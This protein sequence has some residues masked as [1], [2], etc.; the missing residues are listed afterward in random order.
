MQGIDIHKTVHKI[1]FRHEFHLDILATMFAL[2]VDQH[3]TQHWFSRACNK[4]W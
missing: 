3:Y 2:S 4:S 1:R